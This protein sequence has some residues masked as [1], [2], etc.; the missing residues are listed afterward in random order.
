MNMRRGLFRAWILLTIIWLIGVSTLAYFIIPDEVR[1]SKWHYVHH[2]REDISI[3]DPNK[4]DWFRPYYENMRSPSKEKLPVSF[5]ELN[6]EYFDAWDKNVKDGKLVIISLPDHS[7]LYLNTYLTEEDQNYI[8]AAFWNQ[9]WSRYGNIA[10]TWI[11]FLLAPPIVAFI[12]GW[13]LL[14]L[15]RGVQTICLKRFG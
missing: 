15:A 6:Y 14:W 10:K 7:S 12:F 8:A 4:I 11:A 9:R 1:L 2:M 5:S 13:P 3:I